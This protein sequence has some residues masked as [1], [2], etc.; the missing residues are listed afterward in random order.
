[1]SS[2][3]GQSES[4]AAATGPVTARGAG[5]HRR[6]RP[7]LRLPIWL[8]RAH[9]GWLLGD[10]ALMLTHRGRK[11]GLPRQTVL[12]VV[13]H[14]KATGACVIV[15]GWGEKADWC[16][17]IQQDPRV[18][19]HLGGRRFPARAVRL[20]E[21]EATREMAEYARRHPLA[22]RQLGNLLIG[23]LTGTEADYR[24]MAAGMP[25]FALRPAGSP[26]QQPA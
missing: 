3:H 26:A 14:D 23:H 21:D 17:N 20:T 2:T 6:L 25:M 12:E 22:Y 1:M 15:S 8:Y 19:V 5:V 10:R 7:L 18:W 16:R 9:L 11:S 24:A 4:Y 13:R